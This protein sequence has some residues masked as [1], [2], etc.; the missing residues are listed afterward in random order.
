MLQKHI[1]AN[2]KH[3]KKYIQLARN[4]IVRELKDIIKNYNVE[5]GLDNIHHDNNYEDLQPGYYRIYGIDESFIDDE[6]LMP[7]ESCSEKVKIYRAPDGSPY[8][9]K[10]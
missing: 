6:V 10:Y 7:V 4:N 8:L 3:S 1:K 5:H 9:R 2:P